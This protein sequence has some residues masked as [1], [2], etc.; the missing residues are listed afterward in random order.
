MGL[1]GVYWH[2]VERELA[3]NLD[4]VWLSAAARRAKQRRIPL[5]TI[6]PQEWRMLKCAK[7]IPA[8]A[9]D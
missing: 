3:L 6:I 9:N 7:R 8:G 4:S 1:V 2:R 5:T